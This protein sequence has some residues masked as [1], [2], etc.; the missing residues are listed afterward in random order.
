MEIVQTLYALLLHYKDLH[1]I[2]AVWSNYYWSKEFPFRDS[3]YFI[4]KFV[5]A[6]LP[7]FLNH[8]PAISHWQTV[9]HNVVSSTPHHE[10]DSN[11]LTL[12]VIGT[13]CIGSYV[14]FVLQIP[15]LFIL[16]LIFQI[17]FPG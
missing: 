12:V 9:S 15:R 8:Q 13:D 6:T 1:F 7:A 11:K 10:Q 2:M 5:L 17:S 14:V 4:K 16:L 3:A